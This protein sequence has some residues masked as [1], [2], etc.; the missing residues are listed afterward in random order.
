[1]TLEEAKS[2]YLH[3]LCR[4]LVDQDHA[5]VRRRLCAG[6]I[7]RIVMVSRF[8]DV[9]ITDLLEDFHGY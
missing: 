9:G 3:K 7:V 5:G 6:Q 1:M 8:G 4:L 2:K